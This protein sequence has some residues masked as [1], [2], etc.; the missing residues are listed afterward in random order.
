MAHL[1]INAAN[2]NFGKFPAAMHS[3]I[4]FTY[5]VL[6]ICKRPRWFLQYCHG[7]KL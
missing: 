6:R 2:S 3:L 7:D 4:V 1:E 5:V